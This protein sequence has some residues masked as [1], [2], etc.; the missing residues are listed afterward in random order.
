MNLKNLYKN[1][2]FENFFSLHRVKK[3]NKKIKENNFALKNKKY[4]L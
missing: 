2:F 3:E 4:P 1:I